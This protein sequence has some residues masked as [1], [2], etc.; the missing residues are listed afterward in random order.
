MLSLYIFVILQ[1]A[2]KDDEYY[3]AGKIIAVSVVHGGPG[4]R[5][6]SRDFFNHISGQPGFHAVIEEVTD[7]DIKKFCMR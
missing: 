2:A 7:E 1:T 6:L 5:F 3:T 4:P